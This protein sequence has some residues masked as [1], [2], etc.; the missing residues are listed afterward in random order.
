VAYAH[1]KRFLYLM[2]VPAVAYFVVFHYIPIYGVIIAFKDFN[3]SKGIVG[4]PWIGM[5]NFRYMFGLGDFWEVFVNSLSISL[6]RLAIGFPF[7]ILFALLLNEMRG[8]TYQK[9]TQTII[10]FPY[11]ISWVVIGGILVMFLSPSWGV[12]NDFIKSLGGK[13]VF[14][15]AERKYFKPIVVLSDIWK[16]AGWGSIIYI[17]AIAGINP[18]LYDAATIDGARRMQ[19]IRFITLPSIASVI[20]IM[21]ILRIGQIMNNGFEQIFILQNASNLSYSEVFETY[22]YRI[23][24]V[25]GRF[26]FGTTVGLF[27]S[28]IGFLLLLAANRAAAA[29]GQESIW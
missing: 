22:T 26:S 3:F 13:P 17:A 23:G 8:R 15:L 12:F 16:N 14:F 11:F 2:L 6:L 28:S 9:I 18:E 29:M 5:E 10:Y 7:P 27:T 24:L 19:M 4:S 25:G 1:K 21:L 20:V